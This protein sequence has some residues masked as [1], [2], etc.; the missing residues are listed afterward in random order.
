MDT[1]AYKG[2][3]V[4]VGADFEL[5]FQALEQSNSADSLVELGGDINRPTANLNIDAQLLRGKC[6]FSRLDLYFG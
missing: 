5:Q 3:K 6:S 4:V 2:F 1:A